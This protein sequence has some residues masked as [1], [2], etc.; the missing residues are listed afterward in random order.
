[1]ARRARPMRIILPEVAT[2]VDAAYL[3]H[4]TNLFR[5]F[6]HTRADMFATE[7]ARACS[8]PNLHIDSEDGRLRVAIAPLRLDSIFAPIDLAHLT[9][10]WL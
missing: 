3:E 1:M 4:A 8:P 9:E 5:E 10:E 2:S 6:G 7:P